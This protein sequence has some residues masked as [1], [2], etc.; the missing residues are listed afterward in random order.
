MKLLTP[1][2]SN[3]KTAKSDALDE[4]LTAILH[5]APARLS[6][7][8]VCKWASL[9]CTLA[10]LNTA[11]KFG[12]MPRTQAARVRKTRLLFE[13]P[14]EFWADLKRDLDAHC[15]KAARLDKRPAARLNGTA[16]L[17]WERMRDPETG[18]T[19]FELYPQVYF[20][21]YTKY[22]YA[23]RPDESLP[24]NYSLTFS[25]SESNLS[26]ALECLRHGRNVA[27]V[28]DTPRGK[29]LP[30]TWHGRTVIDGDNHDLRFTDGR[31]V[32][33]GLRAKGRARKDESGFVQPANL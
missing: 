3:P 17:P 4:Y 33:V 13:N 25:L 18:K 24:E 28:F 15:R 11:G 26:Q 27:V 20:Y 31:G 14:A 10:C 6:G 29:P 22:P 21:D 9:G 19:V 2:Q 30:E 5:L 7:F 16:D 12:P 8:N 23:E 32:V 1:G